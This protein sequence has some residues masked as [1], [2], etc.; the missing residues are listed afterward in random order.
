M[1]NVR[2]LEDS[3]RDRNSDDTNLVTIVARARNE[4]TDSINV[5]SKFY[6]SKVFLR[7]G[8][9]DIVEENPSRVE[10]SECTLQVGCVLGSKVDIFKDRK[11][12]QTA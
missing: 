6:S 1:Q 4:S 11:F 8:S 5:S 7:L 10:V 12:M 3:L 9:V 2:T